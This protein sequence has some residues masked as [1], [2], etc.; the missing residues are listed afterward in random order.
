MADV[1]TSEFEAASARAIADPQL[2]AVL[3]RAGGGFDA[4][5]V[6]AIQE[7]SLERWEKLREEAREIKRHT[8]D[9]LDY[10]LELLSDKIVHNGGQVHFARDA[11]EA[12]NTIAELARSEK[13]SWP[14][15][16][17]QWCPRRSVLTTPS[18]T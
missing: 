8:V 14:P 9:N 17:S 5:R 3:N 18:P 7:F 10:Y 6:E 12:N 15:R 11:R 16:V 4:A 1:K 13:S 2:Q